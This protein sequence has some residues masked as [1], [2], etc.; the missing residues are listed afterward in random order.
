MFGRRRGAFAEVIPMRQEH[1]RPAV[2]PAPV[3]LADQV[4]GADG[5]LAGGGLHRRQQIERARDEGRISRRRLERGQIGPTAQQQAIEAVGAD[6]GLQ[7]PSRHVAGQGIAG[8]PAPGRDLIKRPIA[9]EH[10]QHRGGARLEQG[11]LTVAVALP[12]IEQHGDPSGQFV[13]SQPVGADAGTDE[14]HRGVLDQRP[15]ARGQRQ[16][17]PGRHIQ[18]LAL[19]REDRGGGGRFAGH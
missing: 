4:V 17:R 6:E 14:Q 2:R 9:V 5:G 19:A 11:V 8:A 18:S 16:H 10:G 1:H 15:L 12:A 13:A 7:V 3:Q